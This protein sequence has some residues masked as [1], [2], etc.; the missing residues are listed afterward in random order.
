MNRSA[1]PSRR[2]FG[3]LCAAMLTGCASKTPE[4]KLAIAE[5][6]RLTSTLPWAVA[7]KKGYLKGD[8]LN[9]VD[10]ISS[11]V[12]GGGLRNVLASNLGVGNVG[13]TTA[14]AAI[15]QG[16]DLR[17]VMCNADH[18][19]DLTWATTKDS[20]IHSI[21][22]L[23]GKKVA[24]TAPRSTTEMVLR[25]ALLKAG[26]AGKVEILA[27]GGL[28]PGLTALAHGA[29]DATPLVDPTLTLQPDK[30]RILFHGYDI[31]PKF[32][33]SVVVATREFTQKYP[34]KLRRVLGA[35]RR[36]VEFM[37]QNRDETA[38]I[39]AQLFEFSLDDAKKLLPKYYEWGQWSHGQFSKEGLK[40]VSDGMQLVGQ[41]DK[42]VDWSKVI[43]QSFLDPDQRRDLR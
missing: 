7:F 30:Y 22:D 29:V 10:I 20:G 6:G 24:F 38:A 4:E 1:L 12:G 8:G 26:L 3:A 40:A 23:A 27:I 41:I 19:G 39:Y 31:F 37:E 14:I 43:D 17:I 25:A 32:T 2:T 34:G 28:G 42:P 5:Y 18:I 16:M 36:A 21:E 9:V 13:T 11:G 33:Y 35:R 15:D